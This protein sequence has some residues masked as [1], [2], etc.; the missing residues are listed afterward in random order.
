MSRTGTSSEG[1]CRDGTSV[2]RSSPLP[3][4]V[5]LENALLERIRT[6]RAQ[7]WRPACP[8]RPRSRRS[9]PSR[10]RR[11]AMSL[12]R[13]VADGHV[14]RVQGLGS[15]VARPRPMHQ[16][17]LN[18]FTENMKAQGF[19]PHR[20]LLRSETRAARR[21]GALGA[22]TAA[23]RVPVRGAARC[24]PTTSR[25]PWRG[26]GCPST[27][28]PVGWTSSRRDAL[29]SSSLYE[30][31]QG[32][33]IGLVLDRGVETVRA[34]R[35]RARSRRRSSGCP[36]GSPTLVVRRTSF[37]PSGRPVEWSVMTFAADRYEYHVELT[38]P[39]P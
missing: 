6:A 36:V 15:F 9:T 31:L 29:D 23:R 22:A 35:R 10:G 24:S 38:R 4:Y 2:D 20:R 19:R 34:A 5:Q 1:G 39:S 26:R 33:E 8:P 12:N 14:E 32:P 3:L 18:S 21:R 25:S 13:M 28:S 17:L 7:A 16:S 11:S 30:L 37:T 27:A